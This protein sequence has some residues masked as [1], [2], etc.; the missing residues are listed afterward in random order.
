MPSAALQ[1]PGALL[2]GV[3]FPDAGAP[4]AVMLARGERGDFMHTTWI[5]FDPGNGDV[6][7]TWRR[8]ENHSLGDWF[9]WLLIPLHFGTYWG[10][11]VKCIWALLGVSMPVLAITG[12]LMYWNRVFG[13]RWRSLGRERVSTALVEN[14]SR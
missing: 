8:G 6:V 12:V 10:L 14:V 7:G 3:S 9:V 13:K 2:E 1:E 5:Y 11:T 4:L